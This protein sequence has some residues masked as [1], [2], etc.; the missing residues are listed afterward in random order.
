MIQIMTE[1]NLNGMRTGIEVPYYYLHPYDYK[2]II[3]L[4][5]DSLV[6]DATDLIGSI[7]LIK[8]SAE[9]EYVKK[10]K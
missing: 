6:K 5:G 2:K 7:R 10:A 8:S 4:I 3:D 9:L 1:R